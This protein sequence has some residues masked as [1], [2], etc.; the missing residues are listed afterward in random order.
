MDESA[1]APAVSLADVRAEA[2][3]DDGLVTAAVDGTGRLTGLTLEPTI[4]RRTSAEI[5]ELVRATVVKAQDDVRATAQERLSA[6]TP[7]LPATEELTGTLQALQATA[8]ARL[9]EM[10]ATLQHLIDRTEEGRP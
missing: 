3:S 9:A 5:A 7:S 6:T 8:T 4:M 10:S 2:T 1:P